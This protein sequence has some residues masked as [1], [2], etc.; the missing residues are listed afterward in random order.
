MNIKRIIYI[1]ARLTI[2]GM[3]IYTGVTHWSDP[4]AFAKAIDAYRILPNGFLVNLA[5]LSMPPLEIIAGFSVVSGIFIEG[6]SL[7]ISGMLLIF[8]A[9]L[10][11]SLMRGLDISCG[12]FTT[13]PNAAKIT[14]WYML[15]DISLLLV[16][17]G[18]LIYPAIVRDKDQSG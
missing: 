17:L 4:A 5:A 7:A 11:A 2:G 18:I 10:C 1:L 16:S 8:A 13:D 6:G 9:A 15:R 3:F 12:C 14:W